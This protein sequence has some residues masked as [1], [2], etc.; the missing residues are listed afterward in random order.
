[1]QIIHD[2]FN[3]QVKNKTPKITIYQPISYILQVLQVIK[4]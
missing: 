2:A 4:K 1:M 3:V